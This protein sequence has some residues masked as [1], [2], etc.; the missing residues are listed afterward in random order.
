[1]TEANEDVST[2]RLTVLPGLAEAARMDGFDAI[3]GGEDELLLVVCGIIGEWL[4]IG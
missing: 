2:T 3:D 4:A 1:M